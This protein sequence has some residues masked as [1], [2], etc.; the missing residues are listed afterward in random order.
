MRFLRGCAV[1]LVAVGASGLALA[2]PLPDILWG[3]LRDSIAK[4]DAALAGGRRQE[5]MARL[6]AILFPGGV[7]LGLDPGSLPPGREREARQAVE[8]AVAVWSH[9]LG[10]GQPLRWTPGARDPMVTV[11]FV[12]A[13]PERDVNA[14]GF[15][16]LR[17][18]MR[19]NSRSHRWSVRGTIYILRS[20]EGR[21]LTC[22]D[23]VHIALHEIG[24]LLGLEDLPNPEYLMGP[25]RIGRPMPAPTRYEVDAV[26]SLR[27]SLSRRMDRAQG[28][29]PAA[30]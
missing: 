30:R 25:M 14:L 2:Q 9:L 8:R 4:A 19:W 23:W 1:A 10:D 17:Q 6:S 7:T 21:E 3:P 18:E 11:R 24:H 28:M 26:L 5:A 15:I 13:L 20:W 22:E 16:D 12:D 27:A 29:E